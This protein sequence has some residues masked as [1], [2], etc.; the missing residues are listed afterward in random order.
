M[1]A[2]RDPRTGAATLLDDAVRA[3]VDD[4]AP[5]VE[6]LAAGVEDVDA[7]R[8]RADVEVEAYNLT[9]A[10]ID[11]DGLHTD[12]EL[13][14]LIGVFG[15]RLPSDL[16]RATPAHVREAG[17]VV[18]RRAHLDRVSGLADVLAA[19]DARDGGDRTERL[20]RDGAEIGH[21]VAALDL[22]PARTELGAVESF[23]ATVRRAAADARASAGPRSGAPT[24]GT[25]TAGPAAGT[26]TPGTPAGPA[27]E[28]AADPTAAPPVQELGPPRPLDELLAEL[29]A[30]VGLEGVKREVHLVSNLLRV[31]Q[32]RHERGLPVL[33]QSRHLIFT[34]NPGTGKTTVARLLAQIYRT[35]GVVD[36]GHLVET[37]RA[38]LVAGFVGQTAGRVVA[39]FDRA[40]GGV[41]L[42]D[43]AYSLARGGENDF[44][45]EAIDTIVKLVED[46]RDRL[47]VILAGYPDEMDALVAANPG[48][49]SRFPRTIHFPD[50][51]DDDL[52]AIVE[53]LGAKGRYVL[54][55]EGRAAVRTWLAAQPR[56]HGFGNGRLARNLFE[57]AVANQAT[58]LV[59]V[60]D[61][62]DD[63]LTT[64]VAAD[65]PTP[66]DAAAEGPAGGAAGD[67]VSRSGGS[68]ATPGRT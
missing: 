17:L 49:R 36:R 33:D 47:V 31:Q 11:A 5:E 8:L 54:D 41:L 56:G 34:G 12:E 40:E 46:R 27:G 61:P 18:G 19:A 15:H 6:A 20:A 44:G 21:A 42:I 62:T 45:R 4:L 2:R 57:A 52:L 29:D 53:T 13:W 66:E 67:G 59:A 37:D 35:L 48:M 30:L 51:S 9:C 39:A 65:I 58:R 63:Q 3:F 25:P 43:E 10:F 26:P 55:D 28:A 50:Y 64:L 22:L 24:A 14:A 38:G 7:A 1:T 32:L 23:R 68:G 60:D 16:G